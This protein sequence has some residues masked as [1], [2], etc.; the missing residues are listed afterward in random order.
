MNIRTNLLTG[1]IFALLSLILVAILPSQIQVPAFD[2]GGP[3]P[4]IIPYMVLFGIFIT[5]LGLIFQSL[6]M[7]KEK[8]FKYDIKTQK[9]G[10]ISLVIINIFG[11]VMLKIGFLAAIF[12]VVPIM[13]YSLGE[14]KKRVYILTTLISVGV[15]FLFTNFFNISLPVFGGG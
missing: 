4:R 12:I 3:S 6:V 15:Y 11:F 1:I 7:K 14:R 5:S 9:S 10:I 8:I 2:N 13:I